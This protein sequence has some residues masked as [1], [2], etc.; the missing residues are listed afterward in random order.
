M[1][2]PDAGAG[3]SVLILSLPKQNQVRRAE[4]AHLIFYSD[5]A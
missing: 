5:R 4:P 1:E 3:G 2:E